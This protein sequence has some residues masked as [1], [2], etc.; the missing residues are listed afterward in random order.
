MNINR[1]KK[2]LRW[3]FNDS[4]SVLGM[5]SNYYTILNTAYGSIPYMENDSL[6]GSLG[7]IREH[8]LIYQCLIDLDRSQFRHLEALYLDEY[9]MRYPLIIKNVFS[10]KTGLALCLHYNMKELMDLCI[11]FRHKSLSPEEDRTLNNLKEL[12]N[13][14]YIKIHKQLQFNPYIV[15]LGK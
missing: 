15:E 9:Q 4:A 14:T 3:Y 13:Q 1:L 5:R 2:F 8:R 10:D 7:K 6:I 11:K 12:T